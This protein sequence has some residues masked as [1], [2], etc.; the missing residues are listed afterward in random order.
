M[1]RFDRTVR[2]DQLVFVTVRSDR[3]REV[4]KCIYIINFP[5]CKGNKVSV[6]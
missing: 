6:V 3:E 4:I 5:D 1:Q 2:T